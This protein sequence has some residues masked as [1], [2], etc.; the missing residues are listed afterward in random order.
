MRISNTHRQYYYYYYYYYYHYTTYCSTSFCR[1]SVDDVKL[2]LA[3]RTNVWPVC[4]SIGRHRGDRL[5]GRPGW[6]IGPPFWVVGR[7]R[8]PTAVEEDKQAMRWTAAAMKHRSRLDTK[9][10]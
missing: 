9:H 10:R 1:R 7:C 5:D 6:Y 3:T 4:R 8:R 2:A